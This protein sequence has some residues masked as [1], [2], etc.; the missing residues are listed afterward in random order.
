MVVTDDN[1]KIASNG[2]DTTKQMG[3]FVEVVNNKIHL[4]YDVSSI[5]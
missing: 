3:I 2:L 5:Y 4:K 1:Q